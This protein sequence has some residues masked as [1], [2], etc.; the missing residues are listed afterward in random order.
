MKR[1][2]LFS[3]FVVL[4]L[5][6][7][8][9]APATPQIIEVP[10]EVVVEKPVV[11]TVVV[12]KQ[13]PVEKEVVK[14]VVVEKEKEVVKTVEVTKIVEATP[15]PGGKMVWSR[16]EPCEGACGNPNLSSGPYVFTYAYNPAF[17]TACDETGAKCNLPGLAYKWEESADHL[18]WT[19]Y[20]RK[21]VRW[22]DGTPSTADDH[23]FTINVITHPDFGAAGFQGTF[24]DVK[25]MKDYQDKKADKLAGIE[26]VDDYTFKIVWDVAKRREP[27]EFSNYFLL[28]YHR[29][30]DQ[31][32]DQWKD[33]KIE[34]RITVGP[35]YFTD[36]VYGQYY[37]MKANPYFYLGKP[38]IDEFIYRAIPNWAVAIAGLKS[39]E[40]DVVDVTPLDEV[41]G[42]KKVETL[43]I[44]PDAV[45]RGYMLWFNMREGRQL[46]KKVRQA[47]SLAIDRQAIIDTMWEG[48]GWTYP[49][50]AQPQGIPLKG[51]IPDANVYDPEKAKQLI[52]E[53]K[54]EG[55]NGKGWNGK[56]NIKLQYYY[57]TEFAKNLMTAVADMWK[58]VGLEVDVELLPTDKVVE[59]FYDKGEYDVLYGC[60]ADPGTGEHFD[61]QKL[62]SCACRYPAG[63]CGQGI[64]DPELDKQ[65]EKVMSF[66]RKEE[67]EAVQWVCTWLTEN[68]ATMPMWMSPGLWTVNARLHNSIAADGRFNKYTH[69]WWIE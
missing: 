63:W 53:A 29:M 28:P 15:K 1:Y 66:D 7:S 49:C 48:Y 67:I 38:R 64:C 10:K 33:M 41:P 2:F 24:K 11:Q 22:S 17:L 16:A 42:L 19:F 13:V 12:E 14:T 37:A 57:T 68:M 51:V 36:I 4:G 65:L 56:D 8:A 20:L 26:K 27:K 9:C 25:G 55:W 32:V 59:V 35:W 21:D 31:T 30:K 6:F 34:D 23:V 47:M 58:A 52:A 18:T 50:Q 60:C 46:P 3:L 5:V 69:T 39:G 44:I 61:L 43:N 45:A 54:K 62:Y 40:I